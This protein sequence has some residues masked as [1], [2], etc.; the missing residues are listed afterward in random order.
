MRFAHRSLL[1]ALSV[2]SLA[3]CIDVF[4][5]TAPAGSR[6]TLAIAPRFS[7]NATL[8]SAALAQA[9][10]EFDHVRIVIVRPASD[11]LKDTTLVFTPS[12]SQLTLE[13]SIAAIPSETVVA[14][15]QFTQATAQGTRVMFS[16]SANVKAVALTQAA[17]AT[18]AEIVVNYTGPGSNA[19][20]VAIQPGSGL[21]SASSSTQFTARAL[22]GASEVPDAPIF[23]S[24]SDPSK[25]AISASGLLTPSGSRGRVVV[26]ATT[27][28][29][30][31]ASVNVDLAPAAAGLR[32]VQGASQKGPAGSILPLQVIVEAIAADGLPATAAGLT[33]TFS[34]SGTAQI[35]PA[36]VAFDADG[37]AKATMKLGTAPGTTYIYTVTAGAF[38]LSWGGIAAAGTPKTFVAE[39]GTS[40]TFRAGTTPDPIP[41][42]RVA[43]SLDNSV[44]GVNVKLTVKKDG[45][46]IASGI[47]PADSIGRREVYRS[48][49][50]IAGTYTILVESVDV[51]PAVPSLTYTIVIE[52][53]AAAKLAFTQMPA[54]VVSGQTVSPAIVVTIQDQYGNTVTAPAQNVNLESDP[55]SGVTISG[56]GSVAPVNGVATFS[57][58]QFNSTSARTGVKIKAGGAGLPAVASPAFN[59]TLSAV[60]S[61]ALN[62]TLP[63]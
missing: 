25:A 38:S 29:G 52:P 34:A 37:R 7:Q 5:G 21:Y 47:V 53:A 58:V 39:N 28:N 26:T 19:T 59:I 55:A 32:I 41:K 44:P 27:A 22:A 54:S 62:V 63:P 8:A 33:A 49:F 9:G 6:A 1:A 13:L 40:F 57:S 4:Q 12:S 31:S 45:V 42:F 2:V 46:E 51:T 50:T 56:T 17:T 20:S 23:W 61:P 18:P 48:P 36:S 15:L 43:D 14:S 16:G 10:L 11:T 30:V 35:S 60:G 3:G 24:V